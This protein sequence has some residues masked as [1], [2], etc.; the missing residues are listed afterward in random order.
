MKLTA[1]LPQE[2][3]FQAA[4]KRIVEFCKTSWISKHLYWFTDH[5][6]SHSESIISLLEQ[7][8]QPLQTTNQMLTAEEIFILL[9][10]VYLHDI[11]MQMVI[12][13]GKSAENL[14]KK[15]YEEIRKRHAEISADI[16]MNRTRPELERD[17][18]RLPEIPEEYLPAIADVAQGHSTACFEKIISHLQRH[19]H[20]PSNKKIRGDL[21]SA[22]LLIGDEL[23][24]QC[25]RVDFSETAF[26]RLSDYSQLHWYKHHYIDF[27]EINQ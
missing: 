22:L 8:L 19:P 12:V 18:I 27:V 14:T 25:R 21:L 3:E 24:L 16:I 13:N 17:D 5:S 15:E 9:S 1:T 7:I 23:D 11:G 10:A 20:T 2:S 6:V 4:L 26:Y